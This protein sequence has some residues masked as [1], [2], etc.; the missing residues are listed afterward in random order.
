MRLYF[1]HQSHP[2]LGIVF[3]LAQP[4]PS[5]WS[6]FSTPLQ[7]HIGHLPT[8]GVLL[9]V[10]FLPFDTVHG[11]LKARIQ[12]WFAIPFSSGRHFVRTLHHDHPSWVA[13]HGMAHSFIELDK[14]V[15]HAIRIKSSSKKKYSHSNTLT[16]VWQSIQVLWPS[17]VDTWN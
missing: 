15:V 14:D 6:Y 11:V 10:S 1:H 5:F 13:L 16:G 7:E 3:A 8:W 2:Q 12:K 17:Q 9:S 4:L